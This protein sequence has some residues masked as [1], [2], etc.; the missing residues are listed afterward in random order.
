V[1]GLIGAGEESSMKVLA[2]S[3]LAASIASGPAALAKDSKSVAHL[4]RALA[5]VAA[6][7]QSQG[8]P[9][10]TVDKDQGDD[11]ASPTAILK[12]CSKDTPAARRSAICP[13]GVS[14]N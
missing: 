3:I 8:P 13:T 6:T 1:S 14:P 2:V 12:V 5:T 10:K 7:A 11:H 4:N 9:P